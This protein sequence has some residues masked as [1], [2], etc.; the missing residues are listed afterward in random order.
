MSAF[1]LGMMHPPG[2]EILLGSGQCYSLHLGNYEL[3]DIAEVGA[4]C[5]NQVKLVLVFRS[6]MSPGHFVLG[7]C[8]E[9]G[10]GD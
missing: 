4:L 10:V 8:H 2:L 9:E 1:F 5:E 7:F 3:F 6:G